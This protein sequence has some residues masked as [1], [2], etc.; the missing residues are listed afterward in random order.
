MSLPLTPPSIAPPSTAANDT[1]MR[2]LTPPAHGPIPI[3]GAFG[4]R[5]RPSPASAV[6]A[7]AA[8]PTALHDRA[9]N[10]KEIEGGGDLRYRQP[11]VA[12]SVL[13]RL[14]NLLFRTNS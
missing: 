4:P 3:P 12:R 11:G 7:G 1:A 13:A 8:A 5:N 6:P 10:E 14:F 9:Q 2:I